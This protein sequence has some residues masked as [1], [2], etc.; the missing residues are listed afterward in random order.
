MAT[1]QSTE[2]AAGIN[3]RAVHA[4]INVAKGTYN[5]GGATLS[6][7][8]TIQMVKVP[9]GAIILDWVLAG[10]CPLS[11]VLQL[12]VGDDGDDDRFGEASISA[13]AAL[14]RMSGAGAATNGLGYQYSVSADADQRWDT[15][16]LT[17][18]AAG[19]A[20]TTCSLVLMVT[21]YMAPA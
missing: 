17:V 15:I 8:D 12:Q 4:G 16:D 11:S 19:T 5:A 1:K 2:I 6:A 10:T 3:A 14:V 21:Y 20:T 18:A 9:H 7:S 13:T